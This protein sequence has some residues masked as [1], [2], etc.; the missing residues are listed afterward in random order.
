MAARTVDVVAG[1][2]ASEDPY[3]PAAPAWALAAAFAALGEDV[4]VLFP[5]GGSEGTPPAGVRSIAVPLPLRRPGAVVEAAELA[6]AAGARLRPHAE[7]VLRDPLGLGRLRR[8]GGR[9]GNAARIGGFVR[10]VALATFERGH[11]DRAPAGFRDRLDLWRDRR[12]V[13]RLEDAALR[14]ADRLFFDAPGLPASL[15][16]TFGVPEAKFSACVPAVPVLPPAPARDDARAS[17]RIPTDVPVVVVLASSTDPGASGVDAGREA[18]RRVRSFFPGGRLIVAGGDVPGEPGVAVAPQRDG[19]TFARALAA[20]DVA[21]VLPRAPGFD[22]GAVLALRA[23]LAVIVG[24][25]VRWPLEPA[26]AVRSLT[27][28]D[29]GDAASALAELLADPASRRSLGTAGKEYVA[30]FDPG[31]VAERIASLL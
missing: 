22:P 20:S 1:G 31:R 2:P 9:P 17:F 27:S 11:A 21:L 6:T 25:G 4:A 30:A 28:D 13:R 14:E 23:G 5:A 24:P 26:G 19:A 15:R 8:G 29:P 7:I 12:A 16:E 10:E 18:F 3:D